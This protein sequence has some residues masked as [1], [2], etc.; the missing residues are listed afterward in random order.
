MSKKRVVITG[1]GLVTSFGQD[2]HAVWTKI[3]AAENG[4]NTIQKFDTSEFPVHIGGEIVDFDLAE[5]GFTVPEVR[6]MDRFSQFALAASINAVNDSNIKFESEDRTRCGVIIGSG[7][8]GMETL[9]EEHS[10]LLNKGPRR[11]SP[12]C[13]PK[14]MGNA[15]AGNIA[16]KFGLQ[17]VNL[18]LVTACAS[19]AH[20]VGD[21]LRQVQNGYADIVIAGGSEAAVTPLALASFC[22]L[23]A[24][25]RRN[26][27]PAAASRPFDKDR[28]GFVLGEGAGM[29]ILEEY[30]HA[31]KRGAKIY[32]ELAGFGMTCDAYHITAP[33]PE[34]EGAARAMQVAIED[35]G[36]TPDQVDYINA[37]G[38]STPLN[39]AGETAA[40]K[41][42]FGD[43]A[44]KLSVSSTKSE[45]GHL[46][47][48]S[49]GVE[50]V[51]TALACKH[52]TAPPTRNFVE[53]EEGLDLDYTPNKPKEREIRYAMS[54][55]FG[56]GG[57]NAALLFKSL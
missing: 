55:S 6:K 32:A 29:V 19:G 12:F 14:L 36:A 34:G 25:S 22:S 8:G 41:N 37:H 57:H 52:Q 43:H 45:T 4:I 11:V 16:I 27:D 18:A 39:D 30:E 33:H 49:G 2:A 47:G 31:V 40:I 26:D 21:A 28:D 50:A 35:G 10:K 23:K 20:A 5:Y 9:E 1:L 44:Y 3:L 24:L 7:I 42:V 54:N 48:A 46:L 56:F 51:F 13:V 15:A 53:G 17:G 38:T